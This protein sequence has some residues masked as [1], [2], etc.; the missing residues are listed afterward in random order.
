M[1]T[2][3]RLKVTRWVKRLRQSSLI[4]FNLW[5]DLLS[6]LSGSHKQSVS[7]NLFSEASISE[8]LCHRPLQSH[9]QRHWTSIYQSQPSHDLSS[10]DS[11]SSCP[12]SLQPSLTV[13]VNHGLLMLGP[14]VRQLRPNSGLHRFI[15][16]LNRWVDRLKRL[17]FKET[18]LCFNPKSC[19]I[20]A[21]KE[22]N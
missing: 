5:S 14:L 16:G 11:N 12:L 20:K 15:D 2:T 10:D 1:I 19:L 6:T 4:K 21:T 9:P 17:N 18:R 22:T 7:C 13:S 3:R 8:M